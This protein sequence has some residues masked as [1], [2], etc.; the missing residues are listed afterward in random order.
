M[1]NVYTFKA[2][3]EMADKLDRMGREKADYIRAAVAEKLSKEEGD[4]LNH[5]IERARQRLQILL[6]AKLLLLQK[7]KQQEKIIEVV[8]NLNLDFKTKANKVKQYLTAFT[9]EQQPV[10]LQKIIAVFEEADPELTEWLKEL[11]KN[12]KLNNVRQ[13]TLSGIK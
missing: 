12:W 4:F 1:D 13:K 7:K 3:D 6:E 5:E 11:E 9:K 8:E 2:N 10:E